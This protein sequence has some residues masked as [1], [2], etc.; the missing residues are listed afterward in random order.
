MFRP[1]TTGWIGFD[2]GDSSVKAAQAVRVGGEFRIA[3]AA[4]VPR[5][6]RWDAEALTADQPLSSADEL[7]AAASI[8]DGLSGRSAAAVLPMALCDAVQVGAMVA[9]R[10][11]AE[12]FAAQVEAE[13]HQSLD[14]YVLA[15]WPASLQQEKLNVM[16]VPAAWSDS[17]SD[18]VAA[19]RW[20]C[21][22]ID[23]LPWTLARAIV[24]ADSTAPT[25]TIAALDWG[26]GRATLVLVH[27]GSPALVR[28][29]KDCGFQQTIAAV[30]SQLRVSTA[31]AERILQRYGLDDA[32]GG[33]A[34]VLTESLTASLQRL[35]GEVR[36]TLGFWQGQTRGV[37]PDAFV[38]F[39]GG[40]SLSGLSQ[41]LSATFDLPVMPWSLAT[42]RPEDAERLPPAHLLGPALAASALAWEATWPSA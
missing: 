39:G 37:R 40:A 9:R 27:Q 17:V 35:E 28:C 36:R 38:L 30:E 41:R 6:D 13:L 22:R 20:N 18:D 15:S 2:L 26:Y 29:L 5:R 32:G 3:T 7:A 16:T 24:M 12:E 19:G 34:S 4:I 25:R 14:G 1:R 8:C 11:A 42:A 10:G 31:D 21:R 33:S 23:A